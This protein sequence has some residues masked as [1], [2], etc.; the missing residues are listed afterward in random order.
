MTQT[1]IL[2]GDTRR[3]QAKRLIDQAQ[4]GSVVEVKP[5]R[6]TNEQSARMWAMLSDISRAKPQGRVMPPH[7]WKS[8]MMD[9]AGMKPE[10]IPSLDGESVVCV[11]YRSSRLTKAEMSE[12][13][14]C[15]AAYAAE[16]GV[17]LGDDRREAA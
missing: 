10:W 17:T 4:P 14:E 6:R 5:P 2:H 12:L 13:I 1:V 7:K 3:A 15:I 11:G 16:H 8:L 9:A